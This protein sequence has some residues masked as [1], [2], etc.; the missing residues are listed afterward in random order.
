MT[1]LKRYL[2]FFSICLILQGEAKGQEIKGDT[3]YV[4]ATAEIA[5]RFPSMPTS[6][7]T[8]P[9]DAPYNFTSLGNGFTIKAKKKNTKSVPLFVTEDKRTHRFF[10]V[11]KK[12]IDYNNLKETEYDYSTVKKLKEHVKQV[13]DK[14]KHYNEAIA[15]ADKAFEGKDYVSAKEH[16]TK[17]LAIF[18]RAWPKDQ[19]K[20]CNKKIGRGS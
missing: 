7:Y 2:F 4:D 18:N 19:L 12:N 3:I 16:Y 8:I 14:E 10:I 9:A 20:K 5:L 15:A 11:Y 17:A 1:L 6:R 13:E